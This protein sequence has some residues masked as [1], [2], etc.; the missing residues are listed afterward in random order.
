MTTDQII[1]FSIIG[2][3]FVFLVWGRWRYDVVAFTALLAAVIAGVVPQDR[4]FTG[5]GHPA[6]V[7]IALVLIVSRGL[8]ASGAIEWLAR[9]VI[10]GGRRLSLHIGI[11]GVL[12]ASLSAL[13][14]NVAALALLMPLDLQAAKAARR[15][16][17]ATLMPLSFASI[18]GGL[19]TLIGTPP[20]IIVSSFRAR[21]IGEPYAMFDFAPVGAVVAAAGVLFIVLG[22][23][24]LIPRA[25]TDEGPT[26]SEVADFVVEVR[27]RKDSASIGKRLAELRPAIEE[28]HGHVIGLVRRG[29]RLPGYGLDAVIEASDLVVLE[30]SAEAVDAVV[31]SLELEYVGTGEDEPLVGTGDLALIEA[32]VPDHAPVENRSAEGMSLP[33]RFG[34]HLLG[35]R[36]QG[37]RFRE[38]VRRL[39]IKGGDVLL[40][41][42]PSAKLAE[43][44]S[45][46]GVL[47]LAD[48]GLSVVRR[49]KA[50]LA[51]GSFALA[52]VLASLG[53]VYLPVALACVATLMVLGGV[54]P[55]RELYTSIEW[56]VIVLLGAMI[57]IGQALETTGGTA[58][59]ADGI[60]ALAEGRSAVVVLIVL[61]VVTMTLS[62][63]MNNTA[64]AVI[65]APIAVEIAARLGADPDPFLM[66]IAVAA[67]CAFLT[68]IGHK[69]NMLVMGPG[70]YRFGDYWRLGLP[71]EILI[72]LV[73][74]PMILLMWPL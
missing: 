13:M 49:E 41:L 14:N 34:V 7:I 68:P 5:F 51:V 21:A 4:A 8:S 62:D 35:I 56:P 15:S 20:N 37:R 38:R 42:G 60:V 23:W 11:M 72:V 74:V 31:G 61:M 53:L 28:H 24:R 47:P 71:L 63:V 50:G 32:V 1:L 3:V 18:L 26:T 29:Q 69:N 40:L 22:G 57:P 55:L 12:A 25:T 6:T 33:S 16:A 10:D 43:T 17:A 36:R 67:S 64:T 39:Q 52:I 59:I 58:L 65:A 46:M 44:V 54:I 66:A 70:G 9:L 19:V 45:W 73:A 48:R 2:L 27:V 30:A